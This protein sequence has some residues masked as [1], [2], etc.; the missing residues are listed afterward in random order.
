MVYQYLLI[1]GEYQYCQGYGVSFVEENFEIKLKEIINDYFK[2]Q[3]NMNSYH[4][5]SQKMCLDYL[6]MFETLISKKMIL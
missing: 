2:Y 5:N 3:S 1:A 6:E 4:F